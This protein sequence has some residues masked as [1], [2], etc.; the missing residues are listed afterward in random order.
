MLPL[1]GLYNPSRAL[2][3]F[4]LGS[5]CLQ[6]IER[7][8][9]LAYS[10]SCHPLTTWGSAVTVQSHLVV[11]LQV[12]N[13]VHAQLVILAVLTEGCELLSCRQSETSLKPAGL[14][15]KACQFAGLHVVSN[16]QI[17]S[18]KPPRGCNLGSKPSLGQRTPWP[19]KRGGVS[20]P[21][22]YPAT[23]CGSWPSPVRTCPRAK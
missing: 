17:Q 21:P 4:F 8:G 7:C 2:S 1:L 20:S 22:Q 13:R 14:R 16:G 15:N 19:G 3:S 10:Q 12:L 18:V 5:G 9:L 11:P 23:L 6:L